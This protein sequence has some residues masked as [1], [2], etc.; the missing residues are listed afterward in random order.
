MEIMVNGK[1]YE[2]DDEPDGGRSH[3]QPVHELVHGRGDAVV[4]PAHE[5]QDVNPLVACVQYRP[6]THGGFAG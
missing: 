1:S 6:V 5:A 2:V 3:E 4:D